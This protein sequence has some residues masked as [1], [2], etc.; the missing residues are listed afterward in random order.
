[1]KNKFFAALFAFAV[2][3]SANAAIV[4]DNGAPTTT[5]GYGIGVGNSTDDDFTIAAGANVHSVG[6]YF[7]N[8]NGI[9][10]WDNQINYR[11]LSNAA[12]NPGAV[13][14][15]GAGQSVTANLSG[16]NWGC[17]G[18]NAWLVNF[19]LASDFAAAAGT[20]YWLELSGAGGPTP[21]WVTAG[22]G[23][24]FTGGSTHVG[25]DFAFTLAGADANPVPEPASI[26]LLGL[27]LLGVAA[28]RRRKS[29]K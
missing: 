24:G 29:S 16:Y 22:S 1:M 18:G 23:N 28:A 3:V 15:S 6:F 17:G 21:W 14:A 10:G 5:N 13:L 2:S 7:H 19:D 8:Y 20:T 9:T 12:G 4:Y 11:I 25:V 26:A 27:G